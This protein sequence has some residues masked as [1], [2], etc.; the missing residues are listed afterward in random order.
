MILNLTGKIAPIACGLLCCCSM[1]YAQGNDT[2]EVMLLDTV[3]NFLNQG[4]KSGCQPR[5]LVRFIR[6]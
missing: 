5:F 3:G 4:L 1:V 6:T 2:S